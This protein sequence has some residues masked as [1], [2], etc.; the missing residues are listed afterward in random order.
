MLEEK[1]I[2]KYLQKL[3]KKIS[4]HQMDVVLFVFNAGGVDKQSRDSIQQIKRLNLSLLR[5]TLIVLTHVGGQLPKSERQDTKLSEEQQWIKYYKRRKEEVKLEFEKEVGGNHKFLVFL[6]ENDYKHSNLITNTDGQW[7]LPDGKP[8]ITDLFEGILSVMGNKA[9]MLLWLQAPIK[10]SWSD[11]IVASYQRL[12]FVDD[13]KGSVWLD[14]VWLDRPYIRYGDFRRVFFA[15]FR[16]K[17]EKI[18]NIIELERL[19]KAKKDRKVASIRQNFRNSSFVY[20]MY[21]PHFLRFVIVSENYNDSKLREKFVKEG[22]DFKKLG[23][24]PMLFWNKDRYQ[25]LDPK[26]Q[27]VANL[28]LYGEKK[29]I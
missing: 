22:I 26:T 9:S 15:I 23:E 18:E 24:D 14:S 17:G 29:K 28:L 27:K 16:K 11:K 12:L 10:A 6:I 21:P 2:K 1:K 7:R 3:K 13:I 5:R 25:L 20:P 8:F 19:E 4:N